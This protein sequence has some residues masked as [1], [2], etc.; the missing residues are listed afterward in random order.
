MKRLLI[1]ALFLV[2]GI[3]GICKA[4][5]LSW[6]LPGDIGTIGLPFE[7]T[8]LLYGYDIVLEQSIA[9]A[10][11]PVLKLFTGSKYEFEGQVGAVGAWPTDDPAVEP[12]LALGKDIAPYVPVLQRFKSLHLNGFGRYSIS[13]DSLG[14]GLS[15]SYSFN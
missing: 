1:V 2:F 6:Q 8:E 9:G 5:Q 11:L 13:K 7:S 14:A 12:Y 15:V 10:S 4:D 3:S